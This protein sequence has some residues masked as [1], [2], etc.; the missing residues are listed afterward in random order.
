VG[1]AFALFQPVELPAEPPAAFRCEI[2]KADGSDSG[3][4]ILFRLAVVEA[5]GTETIAAE[6]QWIEHDWTP[7]VADLSR[8]AGKRVRIKL[9]ADVGPDDNSSGD[10]ACWTA[11]RLETLGPTLNLTVH[12]RPVELARGPAPLPLD[13]LTVERLRGAKRAVLHYQGI[14]LQCGGRYV[15]QASL[16]GVPLGPLPAAGGREAEGVWSDARLELA[17]EAVAALDEWNVLRIDNPGRDSFKIGR[18]WIELELAV[19]RRAS[20]QLTRAAYT[21]PPEWPHAEGTL[22]PFD[23][24]IEIEI[25]V[26]LQGRRE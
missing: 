8:W 23:A 25:R 22:V 17:P 21:Q 19:G 15:S 16:N 14:G 24:P 12:D 3:D 20:S 18:F 13:G 11:I 7:L 1:Y 4:G 5:D 9:I 10:W 6:K 2:G 26:R